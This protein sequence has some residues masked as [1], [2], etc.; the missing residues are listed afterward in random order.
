MVAI[1]FTLVVQGIN[2]LIACVLLDKLLFKPIIAMHKQE[3][4]DQERYRLAINQA[5]KAVDVVN[6]LQRESI[7]HYQILFAEHRPASSEGTESSYQPSLFQLP[8][9][10]KQEIK[11]YQ[12][13]ATHEI[14]KRVR[15]VK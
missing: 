8:V 12:E 9:I 15:H 6:D 1:N 7:A 2:F 4:Q 5:Q 13:L 11:A 14:L 3:E 10:D